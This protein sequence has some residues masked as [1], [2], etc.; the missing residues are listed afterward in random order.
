MQNIHSR[1]G[2]PQ[3]QCTRRPEYASA[4]LSWR[5]LFLLSSHNATLTGNELVCSGPRLAPS[6]LN[7]PRLEEGYRFDRQS[8]Q[9]LQYCLLFLLL[10]I[11]YVI[12]VS[13]LLRFFTFPYVNTIIQIIFLSQLILLLSMLSMAASSHTKLIQP[14]LNSR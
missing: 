4:P 2:H 7:V 1:Q 8:P 12:I 5:K 14:T 9:H 11:A 3:G 13:I 10:S 6:A